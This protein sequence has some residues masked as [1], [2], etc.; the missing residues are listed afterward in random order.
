MTIQEIAPAPA[1]IDE[2]PAHIVPDALLVPGPP[3]DLEKCPDLIQHLR[4]CLDTAI[5]I[6][7]RH[8]EK[9]GHLRLQATRY[10]DA[11]MAARVQV[12]KWKEQL[13]FALD[14]AAKEKAAEQ[15]A[16]ERAE[17]ETARGGNPYAWVA[18]CRVCDKPVR[19][20]TVQERVD[21]QAGRPMPDVR[22]ECPD[23][24]LA[25]QTGPAES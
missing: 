13:T 11:A 3:A 15:A 1:A 17:L 23:C 2:P 14:L 12:E 6:A 24:Q 21:V 19:E 8:A 5:A 4:T 20:L 18:S 25:A 10:D 7:D 22:R 9:G 16:T